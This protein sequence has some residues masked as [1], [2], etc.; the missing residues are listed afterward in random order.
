[1]S[2]GVYRPQHPL[3]TSRLP[4]TAP[5]PT[6]LQKS[7][8]ERVGQTKSSNASPA[9]P[10]DPRPPAFRTLAATSVPI[11]IRAHRQMRMSVLRSAPLYI[12]DLRGPE[13]VVDQHAD[14]RCAG[15]RGA[16]RSGLATVAPPAARGGRRCRCSRNPPGEHEKPPPRD[17]VVAWM[18]GGPRSRLAGWGFS[19]LVVRRVRLRCPGSGRRRPVGGP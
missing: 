16:G 8:C 9:T 5:L 3:R 7:L 2:T 13:K 17:G 18:E 11:W 14:G 19:C 12:D 10:P 1:M 4:M 15:C 6:S